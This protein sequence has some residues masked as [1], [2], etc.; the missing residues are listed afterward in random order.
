MRICRVTLPSMK[1]AKYIC[2]D[3]VEWGTPEDIDFVEKTIRQAEEAVLSDSPVQEFSDYGGGE[4][5]YMC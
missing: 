4:I 3:D 1:M 2:G 5:E